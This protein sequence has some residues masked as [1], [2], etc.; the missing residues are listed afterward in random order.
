MYPQ[1]RC[2][3]YLPGWV[4]NCVPDVNVSVQHIVKIPFPFMLMVGQ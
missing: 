4:S 1:R 3:N 2:K